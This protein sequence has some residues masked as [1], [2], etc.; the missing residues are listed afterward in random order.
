MSRSSAVRSTCAF[1][2][3]GNASTHIHPHCI[4]RRAMHH[5]LKSLVESVRFLQRIAAC[6]C[7]IRHKGAARRDL[8]NDARAILQAYRA[9][10]A[11]STM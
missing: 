4:H 6:A 11:A 8:R 7:D 5:S 9:A 3:T 2:A 10:T 1:A